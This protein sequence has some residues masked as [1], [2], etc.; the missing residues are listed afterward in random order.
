MLNVN[1]RPIVQYIAEN[2]HRNILR[3]Y[4]KALNLWRIEQSFKTYN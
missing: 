1:C 2:P 4:L 3:F